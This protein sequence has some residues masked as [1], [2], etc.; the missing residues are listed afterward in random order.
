[1][2][3]L[4]VWLGRSMELLLRWFQI[5]Q[6][7]WATFCNF[8]YSDTNKTREKE[9]YILAILCVFNLYINFACLSV[10]LYPINVK[11]AEPIGL[12]FFVRSR[13]T[14]G[15][16]KFSKICLQ[17]SIFENFKNPLSFFFIKSAK[18]FVF[19]LLTRRTP[20]FTNENEAP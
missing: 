1:M 8:S 20:M 15:K 10:R 14:T 9:V 7:R 17:N 12:N 16:I 11:T 3:N 5:Q 2:S 13:V 19:V 6:T 18:F 4:K